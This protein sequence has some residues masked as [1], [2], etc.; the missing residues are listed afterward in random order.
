MI[1]STGIDIVEIEEMR[2]AIERGGDRLLSRIF[3]PAE[4]EYCEQR[5]A[6]FQHYAG[7]FAAKEAALKALGTGWAQGVAWK[8]VEVMN[9]ESG[10]PILRLTGQAERAAA[11][12]GV[13]RI[14]LTLS[15]SARSAVAQIIFERI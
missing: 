2:R 11:E 9:Q 15:H 12:L 1:V 8:D 14:H 10:A 6:K 13:D 3:T 4:R 7:R 5:A